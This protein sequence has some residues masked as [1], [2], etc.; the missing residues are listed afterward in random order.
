MSCSNTSSSSSSYTLF[1]VAAGVL[2]FFVCFDVCCVGCI[3]RGLMK[4]FF[5]PADDWVKKEVILV[6][7]DNKSSEPREDER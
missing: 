1:F 4:S 3:V 6:L 2:C 7:L 5:T